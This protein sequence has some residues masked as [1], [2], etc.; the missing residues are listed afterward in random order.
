MASD[1]REGVRTQF[2]FQGALQRVLMAAGEI[3]YLRDLGLGNLVAEHADNRD[4]LFMHRQHDLEGLRVR[5]AE[6]SLQHRDDEFHRGVIV[7]QQQHLVERRP[8]RLGPGLDR[9]GGIVIAILV[10]VRTGHLG[11]LHC[12]HFAVAPLL[13]MRSIRSA[14]LY[15]LCPL[16]EKGAD[17][18]SRGQIFRYWAILPGRAPA[19]RSDG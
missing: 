19:P 8:L 6:E 16:R 5:H 13:R 11:K 1:R 14:P 15:N 12:H 3:H 7:I 18:D 2:L 4:A 17:R 10:L 9:D